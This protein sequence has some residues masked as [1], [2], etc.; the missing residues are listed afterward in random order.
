V[1]GTHDLTAMSASAMARA[2]AAG[3]VSAKEL[4][5]AHFERIAAVN[6]SLN[7][8]V[9]LREDEARQ[10]AELADRAVADGAELGPLHGVPVTIKDCF[11]VAGLP[12]TVGTKGLVNFVPSQDDVTV[13]RLRDAGAIVV[14]KTNCPELMLAFETDNEV[15]GRTNNPYDQDRTPGGSSGGEA[16]AVAAGL[17]PFGLA[18]DS[19]GSTRIPAHFCGVAG[20]KVNH[21]RIPLTS[22]VFPSTGPI[23]R[24]RSIGIMSRRVEDLDLGLRILSGPDGRDPWAAP[25]PLRDPVRVDVAGL[26][27]AVHDH[28]GI[29]SPTSEI[30]RAVRDTADALAK[31]GASI[32]QARPPSV[33]EMASVL[34][35]FGGDGGAELRRTLAAVGTQEQDV[36]P[37]VRG[38]LAF[39]AGSVKPAGEVLALQRWWDEFRMTMLAFMDRFDLIV[40]P[41]ASVPAVAHGTGFEH[42]LAFSYAWTFNLTGWPV[43]VVRAGTS[44]DGLP[45]GVQLAARP[46]REDVALAAAGVV[47]AALGGWRPPGR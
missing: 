37:L 44:P 2:V 16:A 30:A 8:V 19:L 38:L 31:A 40:C 29:A 12:A 13:T 27:V 34:Q 9:A 18:S 21:G 20:L 41:V 36:S 17:S 24:L 7:A 47:E 11:A 25:V 45:V 33:E 4:L 43:A 5:D 1:T 22:R 26:R 46:W 23:G 32:D 3:E 42:L 28:N 39:S 10:E 35:L 15:Y 6:P 14:G